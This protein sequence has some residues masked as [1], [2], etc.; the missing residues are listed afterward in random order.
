MTAQP[1]QFSQHVEHIDDP[2]SPAPAGTPEADLPLALVR[3]VAWLLA[4]ARPLRSCAP[5]RAAADLARLKSERP[6]VLR[7]DSDDGGEQG[8]GGGARRGGDGPSVHDLPLGRPPTG[9]ELSSGTAEPRPVSPRTRAPI[10]PRPFVSRWT[11]LGTFRAAMPA[12]PSCCACAEQP[13]GLQSVDQR[14]TAPKR[15]IVRQ[16]ARPSLGLESRRRASLGRGSQ[17]CECLL[18]RPPPGSKCGPS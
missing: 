6:C 13:Y 1:G 15:R 2:T 12:P 11:S 7:G 17:N 10:P 14:R 16:G 18:L 8:G 3:D 5:T 9:C 4:D